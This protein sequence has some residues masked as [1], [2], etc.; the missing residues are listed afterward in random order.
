MQSA[1]PWWP[2]VDK[3][4]H[5]HDDGSHTDDDGEGGSE[6]GPIQEPE[7]RERQH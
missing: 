6:A 1:S 3:A 2:A 7:P 4:R 5:E